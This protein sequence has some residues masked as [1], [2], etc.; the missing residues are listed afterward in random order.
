MNAYLPQICIVCFA[1]YCRSPVAE[2]LMQKRFKGKFNIIS[3]GISPLNKPEMDP[4]SRNFLLQKIDGIDMHN[5]K[6]ISRQI[7]EKSILILALD[8]FVLLNLN[9]QFLNLKIK[10]I[11]SI[12]MIKNVV[13]TL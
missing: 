4:R 5:P 8:P 12:S 11:Y 10:Y 13:P 9:K 3:A 7:V 2:Q 1:N 6:R